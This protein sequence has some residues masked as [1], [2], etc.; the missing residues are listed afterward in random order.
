MLDVLNDILDLA[1]N[2]SQSNKIAELNREV[3][4]LKQSAGSPTEADPVRAQ[5]N[6]L[7]AANGEL[8]LYIAV[9]FR[10]LSLKGI[11]GRD[12]LTRLVEQIDAEDGRRDKAHAGDVLP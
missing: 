11:I 12:D 1:W 9:L 7:R 8:R 3:A 4:R 6:E 5:L 2:V 10:V